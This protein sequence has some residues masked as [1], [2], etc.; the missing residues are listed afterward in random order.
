MSFRLVCAETGQPPGTYCQNQVMDYY[1]P[2]ISTNDPCEHIKETWL[3][4]NGQ[5]T[6]CTACL[7][8]A[9]YVTRWLPF[10]PPAL[11]AYYQASGVPYTRLPPHYPACTRGTQ[12]HAPVITSLAHGTTYIIE[13]RKEQ[14][15]QLACT[16]A[17]DVEKVYWYLNDQFYGTAP[18]T[19]KLLFTPNAAQLKISCTD[20][21][22]RTSHLSVR[23]RYL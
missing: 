4:A 12:G 20:D 3:S 23:I 17:P 11:A 22:G 13:N 7:P 10:V 6:Y 1:L 19:G 18:A 21:K 8:P 9:G 15:L 16:A 14:Q 5:F 2:G